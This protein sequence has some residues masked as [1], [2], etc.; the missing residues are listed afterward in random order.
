MTTNYSDTLARTSC[1]VLLALSSTGDVLWWGD[2]A[3]EI[4]GYSQPQVV[5]QP[6][7]AIVDS[8]DGGQ[9]L[10]EVLDETRLTGSAVW[11]ALVRRK[12]GEEIQLEA[13]LR[14][15]DP[16]GWIS[17]S[18]RDVS[19]RVRMTRELLQKSWEL[20]G[21]LGETRRLM[22]ETERLSG[23]LVQRERLAAIG[24]L[25]AG[26]GHDLRNP[27]AAIKNALRYLSKRLDPAKTE[28]RVL[29]YIELAG[30]ELG[31]CEQT[32]AGLLDY[33]RDAPMTFSSCALPG[34]LAE[35]VAVVARPAHVS[36]EIDAP[37]ELPPVDADTAQLRRVLVNLIQNAC[38]AVPATRAGSVRV[39]AAAA[40]GSV[41]VVIS[42]NGEGIAPEVRDRLFDPLFTTKA[43]GTGLG[44]AVV[45]R[46]V[47]R[48]GGE[49]T[50]DS[51]AGVGS[52]FSVRLP[53]HA[54]PVEVAS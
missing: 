30:K 14:R 52:S 25:A 45:A 12:N 15:I 6:L 41:T 33:A 54:E 40:P 34:L 8:I 13:V 39:R 32:I 53:A 24:E 27:L 3:T 22:A 42:D 26:I 37:A 28:Q 5:G 50:V 44:L 29:Q 17:F 43:R 9:R 31:N 2:G 48:H 10:A 51:T 49:V 38:E 46:I 35:S 11:T 1:E 21:K 7:G 20:E 23:A 19:A 47:G 36:I 18:G 4:L 16:D